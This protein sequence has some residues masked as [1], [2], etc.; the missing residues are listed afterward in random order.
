MRFKTLLQELHRRHVFKASITYLVV[1]WLIIQ[2]LSVLVDAFDIPTYLMQFSIVVLLVCFPIWLAISWF[3]DITEDGIVKTK[4]IA[5]DEEYVSTKSINLNKVIIT[6][7]SVIVI[8]LVANTFRIKSDQKN[9]AMPTATMGADNKPSIAVLALADYSKEGDQEYFT[10]GMSEEITNR[11]AQS[12]DL[13]VIGRTSSFSYKDKKVNHRIIGEELDV[14][15]YIEGSVRPSNDTIRITVQLIDVTDGSH[16]WSK[17]Y[18][19]KIE[20]VLFIQDEIACITADL[21]KVTLLSDDR[22][23]RE[24]DPEAYILYLKALEALYRYNKVSTLQADSLINKSLEIDDTYAPSWAV[25]SQVIFAKTY[26][27][28]LLDKEVGSETGIQ[29]AKKTVELDSMNANGYTWLS[30]FAWQ[31]RQPKLSEEYLKKVFLIA[32]NNPLFLRR[33]GNFALRTNRLSHAKVFFDQSVLLDPKN[34]EAFQQRGFYH[35]ALGNVEEAERDLLK[36]YELGL[37]NTFK[38]YELTLINRDK[39]KLGEALKLAEKE[40]NPYLQ[41][42]LQCSI[43]FAMGRQA[44]SLE[45]LEQIKTYPHDDNGDMS[46]DSEAEH[47][48]EIA[49]LYAYMGNADE[50]FAYLDNAF[51]HV[52]IWPEWLFT[53]PEFNNLHDDPR[54]ELYVQRLGKEYNYDFLASNRVSVPNKS[55]DLHL[56]GP[57]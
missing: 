44:E 23:H 45:L 18:D 2:V 5:Y 35:W 16:V 25:L 38:N 55:K 30:L 33:T 31:D 36:A 13:K 24:V 42:L 14:D 39:N 43:Y 12:R 6:S 47:N 11:L 19:R 1:G 40:K 15:Y 50:A 4:K 32:P 28:F 52:L 37:P 22:R 34:K 29:A 26:Y 54:W 41:K 21:L 57:F 17:I 7:L 20:D 51:E 53:M 3:Y 48:F 56:T 46:L 9:M 8:M 27:Y 49:C 10:D